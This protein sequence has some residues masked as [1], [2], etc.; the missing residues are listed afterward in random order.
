VFGAQLDGGGT[1]PSPFLA[2]RLDTAAALLSAGKVRA[3]LVSGDGNG[4]SGDEVTV[5]TRYLL[6]HG[7]PADRIVPDRYGLDT[8]DTCRRARDVYGVRRALLVSQALH[9]HRAITLCR[10]LGVRADGVD[11]GCPGCQP[12]T[13]LYNN[14]RELPA[15]WKALYDT[16]SHRPPA[17]TSPPMDQLARV[18]DG[19]HPYE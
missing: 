15:A 18:V 16:V 5:M 17:V 14:V 1:R 9:L 11:A 12:A 7:V 6:A 13:L 4:G 3:L 10:S 19:N 2:Y 8:Y